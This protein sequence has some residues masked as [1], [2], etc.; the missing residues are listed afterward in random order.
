MNG[1]IVAI[2]ITADKGLPMQPI[3]SVEVVH[4][5]GLLGDR[6]ATGKGA[7]SKERREV[8]RHVSF[9]EREAIDA[10]AAGGLPVTA[11]ITRRNI[12]T[13]GVRL[14]DLVGRTFRIGADGPF[15]RG[16]EL[17]TPCARPGKLSGNAVLKEQLEAALKD[18]GGLRAEIVTGGVIAVGDIIITD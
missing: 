3:E 4:G 12:V 15:F 13:E 1:M 11:E 9:I 5:V 7:W 10:V 6:Y 16:V 2:Y 17:C 8:I 14:N 18:R